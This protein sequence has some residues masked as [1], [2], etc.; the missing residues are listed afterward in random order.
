MF[1]AENMLGVS[2]GNVYCKEPTGPRD[3]QSNFESMKQ[4]FINHNWQCIRNNSKEIVF[5]NQ[6]ND[7]DF[8][9]IYG[10]ASG[11][12]VTVPLKTSTY[13]YVTRVPSVMDLCDYLKKFLD[14][15]QTSN[16]V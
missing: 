8:V 6:L 1:A 16:D 12:R 7:Y 5:K 3:I 9:E 11:F 10:D 13:S 2:M 14:N 4:D 15:Y